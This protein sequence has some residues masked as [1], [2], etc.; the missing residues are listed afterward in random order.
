MLTS[1][2]V[3]KRSARPLRVAQLKTRSQ[4][5]INNVKIEEETKNGS[6]TSQEHAGK[7]G[8]RS[9]SLVIGRVFLWWY[10]VILANSSV[11]LLSQQQH[12]F[13]C[14]SSPT[15]VRA[16]KK[17]KKTWSLLFP[18]LNVSWYMTYLRPAVR[19]GSSRLVYDFGLDCGIEFPCSAAESRGRAWLGFFEMK[20]TEQG[21]L[22]I[23]SERIIVEKVRADAAGNKCAACWCAQQDVEAAMSPGE[24]NVERERSPQELWER[25]LMRSQNQSTVSLKRA[26]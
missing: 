16:K 25:L 26:N 18:L 15:C 21:G 8:G 5:V 20:Q 17:K 10:R 7:A 1:V 13:Y 23:R 6:I 2:S 12:G 14:Y 3:T 4:R 19:A 11:Y 9:E 24:D 22:F